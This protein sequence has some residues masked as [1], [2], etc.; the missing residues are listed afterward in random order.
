VLLIFLALLSARRTQ[1]S[2]TSSLPL[3]PLRP[4]Y[5]SETFVWIAA[6]VLNPKQAPALESSAQTLESSE[7]VKS[8]APHSTHRRPPSTTKSEEE[9][10]TSGHGPSSSKDKATSSSPPKPPRSSPQGPD[11]PVEPTKP[12][13][14]KLDGNVVDGE[15]IDG[16]RQQR[17][18]DSSAQPAKP[19]PTTPHS[20]GTEGVPPPD[21]QSG[22]PSSSSPQ[23]PD[24]PTEPAEDLW[25]AWDSRSTTA[26]NTFVVAA[27]CYLFYLAIPIFLREGA[28]RNVDGLLVVAVWGLI[29]AWLFT[30]I[31]DLSP[32]VIDGAGNGY[33]LYCVLTNPKVESKKKVMERCVACVGW[34]G[35]VMAFS[36]ISSDDVKFSLVAMY[37][38]GLLVMIYYDWLFS[39]WGWRLLPALS[40]NC[41]AWVVFWP[42]KIM[43][44]VPS[45]GWFVA[46]VFHSS[47]HTWLGVAIVRALTGAVASVGVT[48]ALPAKVERWV[49]DLVA[50]A[51]GF[52][53]PSP[54]GEVK[55]T[56]GRD[57][58]QAASGT[59]PQASTQARSSWTMR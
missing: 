19:A 41:F 9:E 30:H 26:R 1:Q 59:A 8:S 18:P 4:R 37:V 44:A 58:I 20:S 32:S 47:A 6:D 5:W 42:W 52:K 51:C 10:P 23:G 56:Q 14:P 43:V 11:P 21:V 2:S 7:Q 25:S 29:M 33:G 38:N 40:A 45:V 55:T 27:L 53:L 28:G 48:P 57:A 39:M 12:E 22:G 34:F 24:P 3:V 17:Q 13:L 54:T 35:T 31:D 36:A 50:R 49:P 16:T 46:L 15:S